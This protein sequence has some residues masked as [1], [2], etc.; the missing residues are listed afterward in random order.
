MPLTKP[1]SEI[2]G[3]ETYTLQTVEIDNQN[4]TY[5]QIVWDSGFICPEDAQT[6][7]QF[8]LNM[9]YDANKT[10]PQYKLNTGSTVCKKVID[11]TSSVN[12]NWFSINALWRWMNSY[13][14]IVAIT[15]ISIG[16]FIWALGLKLFKPTIF[17]VF[18][19]STFFVIML[20]FYA[21]IL[22]I[23]TKDWTVWV[24]GSVGLV[25]GLIVGFFMTKLAR[26]GVAALGAWIG[27][28]GGLLIHEAFL[29][30][31]NQ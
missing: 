8:V 26:L 14:W 29:Y 6:N 3:A 7:L 31:S 2:Q 19:L 17:I 16:A 18:T 21:L 5:L 1:L 27:F 20:L 13:Y 24:I 30:H 15:M 12:Y 23:T 25:L 4:V 28:V 9:W 11:F 10:S 22:P